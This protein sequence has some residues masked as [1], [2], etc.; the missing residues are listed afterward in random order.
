MQSQDI[1]HE[2]LLLFFENLGKQSTHINGCYRWNTDEFK[3]AM[4]K[5]IKITVMLIDS[6]TIAEQGNDAT[7]VNDMYNCALTFLGKEGVKTGRMDSYVEQNEVLNHNLE[8]AK[9]FRAKITHLSEQEELNDV[10]NWLYGRLVKGSF[11]F[12]KVGAIFTEN[13]YGYRLQF[14]IRLRP[15]LI[16]L[17]NDWKQ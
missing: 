5:G 13:L 10:K 14:Q 16:V 1:S 11:K 9:K 7:N 6:P 12:L 4:R 2:Q 8:I 17:K 15:N 3:G